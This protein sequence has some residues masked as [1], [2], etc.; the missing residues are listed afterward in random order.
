MKFVRR[1]SS[2][3]PGVIVAVCALVFAMLGGAY[4]ASDGGGGGGEATASA[5]KGP[6]GPRGPKGRKGATG[7]TGVQGAVGAQGLPGSPGAKGDAGSAGKDGA[8][9]SDGQ[10]GPTG[11]GVTVTELPLGGQEECEETGGA[12]VEEEGE[13]ASAVEVCTGEK[14]EKGGEG[15]P[16]TPNNTLPPGAVLTGSWSFNGAGS[17]G[18]VYVPISFPIQLA[19]TGLTNANVH[20]GKSSSSPFKDT[21]K[22]TVAAPKAPPGKL[23]VYEQEVGSAT[24]SG[25]HKLDLG[26]LGANPPGAIIL[27]T[28]TGVESYGFGS[29]AVTGCGNVA[30]PCP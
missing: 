20:Y 19:G 14:G 29:W 15:Q 10:T 1:S 30:F 8:A 27:F 3:F 25:A 23:C 17:F 11:P 9:G 6:P 26:A 21:C 2:A 22:G 18:E 24:T 7:A 12:L 16:W 28:G 4:A 13:P 5:K